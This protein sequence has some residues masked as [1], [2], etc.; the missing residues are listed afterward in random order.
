MQDLD[1]A[2]QDP[3]AT[4]FRRL[5]ALLGCDPDEMET[6]TVARR[7]AEGDR[8]GSSALEELAAHAA[9]VSAVPLTADDATVIV[10]EKGFDA[11]TQDMVRIHRTG[12]T[13][14]WGTG[15]AWQAGV[16][17]ARALRQQEGLNGEPLSNER[18]AD[19]AGTSVTAVRD[20]NCVADAMSLLLHTGGAHC[21]LALRPKW[22]PGRRFEL[23]RLLGDRL[24]AVADEPLLPATASRTYRQKAQRAFAVELLCPID[25]IDDFLGP[26]LSEDRRHDAAALFHVSPIAIDRQ[27]ENDDRFSAA[28]ETG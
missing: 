18:L 25:A 3:Y 2:R 10:R 26:D 23:A 7:L 21:R 11:S 4:R 15:A 6:A 22:E 28:Y 8:I 19:L 14:A 12:E 5:E 1:E 20:I 17:M 24:C 16:S 27:L 13:P 9:G